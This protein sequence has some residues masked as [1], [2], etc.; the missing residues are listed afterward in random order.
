MAHNHFGAR[1][2]EKF[3]E[4]EASQVIDGDFEN[5]CKMLRIKAI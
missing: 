2:S 1:R 5:L 4:N 3:E